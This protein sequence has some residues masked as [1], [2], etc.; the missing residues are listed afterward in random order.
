MLG[1][2][3]RFNMS[4]LLRTVALLFNVVLG[5]N[6]LQEMEIDRSE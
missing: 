1:L 6:P 4:K 2:F 5:Y 3:Q